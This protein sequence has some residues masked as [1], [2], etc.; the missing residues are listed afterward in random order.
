MIEGFEELQKRI[1]SD[2]THDK[3]EAVFAM[4]K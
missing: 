4:M 3:D 1:E 2:S